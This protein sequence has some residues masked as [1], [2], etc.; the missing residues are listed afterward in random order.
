M[1]PHTFH[2]Y[3]ATNKLFI[4]KKQANKKTQNKL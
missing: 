1:P 3:S 4:M 2:N